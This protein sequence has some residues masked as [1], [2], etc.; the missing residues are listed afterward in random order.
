MRTCR[1]SV[2]THLYTL[3]V[4][5]TGAFSGSTHTFSQQGTGCINCLLEASEA[6]VLKPTRRLVDILRNVNS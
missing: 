5:F 1:F 3:K 4:E 6:E 2:F